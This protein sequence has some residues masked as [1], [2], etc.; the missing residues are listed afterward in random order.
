M[1]LNADGTAISINAALPFQ[2][3]STWSVSGNKFNLVASQD[4]LAKTANYSCGLSGATCVF[5]GD[6]YT[7]SLTVNK[8]QSVI[9]GKINLALTMLVNGNYVYSTSAGNITC[10]KH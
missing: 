3:H 8:A 4:D 6:T 5:V 1:T 10:A 7:T 9:K 2:T